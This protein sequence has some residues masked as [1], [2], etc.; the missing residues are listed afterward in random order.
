[1]KPANDNAEYPRKAE[2]LE[3]WQRFV[4]TSTMATKNQRQNPP[5][6]DNV[7]WTS[8]DNLIWFYDFEYSFHEKKAAD[9]RASFHIVGK[10]PEDCPLTVRY[11]L[12]GSGHS[13]KKY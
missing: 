12:L 3:K 9:R 5:R 10:K 6:I 7:K 13:D 1:M 11:S 4:L 2:L 8:L